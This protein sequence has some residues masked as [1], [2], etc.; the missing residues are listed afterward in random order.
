MTAGNM[1]N[2]VPRDVASERAPIKGG[3]GTSPSRGMPRIERATAVAR[4]VGATTLTMAEL[5]GPV[6]A[7]RSSSVITMADMYTARVGERKATSA[8]GAAASVAHPETR[9]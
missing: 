4:S 9:R 8:A 2:A 1:R 6:E 7:K 3:D 5:M